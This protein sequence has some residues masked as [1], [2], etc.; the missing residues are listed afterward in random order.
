MGYYSLFNDFYTT[1]DPCNGLGLGLVIVE[2]ILND[3]DGVLHVREENN[4]GAVF[5]IVFPLT[6]EDNTET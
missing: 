4:Y 6:D 5:E 2:K 3:L 1:N